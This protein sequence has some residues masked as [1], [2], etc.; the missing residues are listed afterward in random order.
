MNLVS[1]VLHPGERLPI[2]AGRSEAVGNRREQAEL[3]PH[4]REIVLAETRWQ[5]GRRAG[6]DHE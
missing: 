1:L 6:V 3:H 5:L 4:P 2:V